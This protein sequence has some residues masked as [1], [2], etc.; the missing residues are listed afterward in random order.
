MDTYGGRPRALLP[1]LGAYFSSAGQF[2]RLRGSMLFRTVVVVVVVFFFE[3][4]RG[5]G[6]Q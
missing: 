5:E 2:S 4:A 3:G 6:R 1:L